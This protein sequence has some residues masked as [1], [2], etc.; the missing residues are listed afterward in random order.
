MNSVEQ[1]S[2]RL[3]VWDFNPEESVNEK[4]TKINQVTPGL[5]TV[6]HMTQH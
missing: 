6:S 5:V 4:L 3:D 2:M 1:D